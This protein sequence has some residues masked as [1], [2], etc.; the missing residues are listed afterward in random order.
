MTTPRLLMRINQFEFANLYAWADNICYVCAAEVMVDGVRT[1]LVPV[2]I[3]PNTSTEDI[4]CFLLYNLMAYSSKI[5]T[6][7]PRLKRFGCY[8]MTITLTGY[9][10][11]NLKDR[12]NYEHFRSYALEELGLTKITYP[13]LSIT[14]GGS[15]IEIICVRNVSHVRYTTYISYFSYHSPVFVIT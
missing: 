7:W 8:N 10:S 11:F 15:C 12:P 2:Y 5:F 1:L 6:M 9:F 4:E 14:L 3:N 13:S